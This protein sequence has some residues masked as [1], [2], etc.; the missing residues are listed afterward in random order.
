MSQDPDWLPFLNETTIDVDRLLVY[1][2]SAPALQVI[3][4]G[5]AGEK[6]KPRAN[7]DARLHLRVIRP[8]E[9]VEPLPS[10]IEP[11]PSQD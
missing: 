7:P 10:E 6:G 8:E 5:L 4:G 1:L 9:A 2:T 3:E 11:M